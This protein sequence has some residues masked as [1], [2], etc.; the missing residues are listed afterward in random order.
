[1]KLASYLQ[2]LRV[3]EPLTH[4]RI[5]IVPLL[6]EQSPIWNY[7]LLQDAVKTGQFLVQ[8]V[9]AEGRV[10]FLL[11]R[12]QIKDMVLILN[13]EMLEGGKQN[14]IAN[15]SYLIPA[16]KDVEIPVSCV[17]QG[18]WQYHRDASSNHEQTGETLYGA[19]ARRRKHTSVTENLRTTQTPRSD[20]SQVWADV[21]SY[22]ESSRT[23]SYTSNYTDYLRSREADFEQYQQAFPHQPHQTGQIVYLDG[24]FL[25]LDLLDRPQHAAKTY[26]KML[27]SYIQEALD[28]LGKLP[29]KEELSL[30]QGSSTVL[31]RLQDMTA[32]SHDSVGCGQ[33]LRFQDNTLM[34]AGLLYE[35]H[36]LHL[37]VYP[38]DETNS[39]TNTRQQ[40]VRLPFRQS[41]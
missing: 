21:S 12:N 2:D 11:T 34:G 22:L 10:P 40:R 35:D 25:A 6:R 38:Y 37:E 31:S 8:E 5:T 17:E 41:T 23:S 26:S 18:R 20:Q 24:Q 13:G 33:D 30:S 16:E 36:L 9:S 29:S 19:S 7:Q 32:E 1:M 28:P 3:G 27:R 15:A 14:R 39:N 4:E